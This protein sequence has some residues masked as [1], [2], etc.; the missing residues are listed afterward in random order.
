MYQMPAG[1]PDVAHNLNSILTT[2]AKGQNVNS[3]FTGK[4][5][6]IVYSVN[7][8]AQ[9]AREYNPIVK[10]PN[11]LGQINQ[12]SRLKLASQLAAALS[13]VIVIP[14]EGLVTPR[15][16]FIKIN[17][18]FI[19]ANNGQ[20]MISYENIQLTKGVTGLP[21]I[22]AERD[23]EGA[24]VMHLESDASAACSRVVYVVFKKTNEN[25]LQFVDSSVVTTAGDGGTFRTSIVDFDGD[26]I[27][28]AYGM[29]DANAGASAKYGNYSVNTGEDIAQLVMSRKLAAGDYQFT[30]TRGTTLF[31]NSQET[32]NPGE[33]QNMVYITASGPGSVSGTGFTGNRKAVNEGDSVTVSAT[34]NANCQFL[35]WK[36]QGQSSYVSTANPYTFTPTS[37]VDLIGVFNNPN[38]SSGDNDPEGDDH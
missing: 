25:Q 34:P 28:W 7:S 16:Q 23:G 19:T 30:K 21:A 32:I 3:K 4:I 38:S 36:L 1:W 6:A 9:I 13:S 24:L 17:M 11:T 33:N 18:D 26:V 29:K 14:R 27:I 8:G 15:N 2:M 37:I 22:H 5:G 35:G 31:D 12:R 10:N 20:S